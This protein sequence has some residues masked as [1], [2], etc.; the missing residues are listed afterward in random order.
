MTIAARRMTAPGILA[1]AQAWLSQC[2]TRH[3]ASQLFL[4]NIQS[5]IFNSNDIQF[6]IFNLQYLAQ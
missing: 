3:S 5:T 1:I 6:S 4:L 2:R